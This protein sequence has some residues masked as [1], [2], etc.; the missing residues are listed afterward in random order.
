[1][2]SDSYHQSISDDEKTLNYYAN[3]IFCVKQICFQARFITTALKYL[4]QCKWGKGMIKVNKIKT[5][6]NYFLSDFEKVEK[7][8]RKL[9]KFDWVFARS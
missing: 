1:M 3:D 5:D 8:D 2:S 4:L 9:S 6:R 7:C